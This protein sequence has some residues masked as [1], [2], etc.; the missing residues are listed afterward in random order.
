MKRRICE[1]VIKADLI[2]QTEIEK[3]LES[4]KKVIQS[5]AFILHDNDKYLNEKEAK[6]NGKSVGD[7]KI[8]HWH[9]MLRFHQ[10]QE[11][12]YI[13]KWFNTTE[14]FVSQIKGRFTD[15]LLYL[16]HANRADKHQYQNHQ[17]VSNFD[18]ESEANQDTFMRKYKLDTRLVDILNKINSGEIKEY[19]ITNHITIIENNIYSAAIE[20][21][22]KYRNSKLREMD[23]KMECV[24][25]TGQSG[26]GKTTLAKQISKNKNYTPFISSGSNDVLDGYKGQECVIL[27]DL[28]AD[29]FGVS[30]LLKMLD[31]NTASS[32]KSRYRNKYLECNLIIITTTKTLN[33]FFDTVFNKSDDEDVK[34]LKRRCR[35]H[36][37]LDLK[38]I[39]YSIYNPNTSEY[40][41][42]E[43]T[44]NRIR[45]IFKTKE[46][47]KEEKKEFIK[48]TLNVEL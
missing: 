21:A 14:N 43:K 15:A 26:S 45:E 3:V 27:D 24:F 37:K 13:A 20:K 36:I 6:E 28:R 22:F 4:K 1:L 32:V 18:W 31:N 35:I 19:N 39:T 7:Y 8:P 44:P 29:C 46:Q 23:K 38:N 17:V 41:E 47:S 5:Y 2:K 42:V 16:T 9:I 34:Q 33:A 40:E 11:F 48:S 30:D 12:K 25:I 10:S